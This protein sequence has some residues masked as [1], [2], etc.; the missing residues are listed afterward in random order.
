M[1]Y[2]SHLLGKRVLDSVGQPL[3]VIADLAVT[4]EEP[5]GGD[6]P[7]VTL[8]LVRAGKVLL[9]LRWE[10]IA[11]LNEAGHGSAVLLD[12]PRAHLTV[13]AEKGGEIFLRRDVLDKQIID[14]S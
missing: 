5:F 13:G 9:R 4:V 8:V 1:T 11:D 14:M 2:L 7:P 6:F 10:L 12:T 3:G